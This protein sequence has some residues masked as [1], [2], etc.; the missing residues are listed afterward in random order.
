MFNLLKLSDYALAKES[1]R[2]QLNAHVQ[3]GTTP[4]DAVA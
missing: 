1:R 2:I 4:E 3:I